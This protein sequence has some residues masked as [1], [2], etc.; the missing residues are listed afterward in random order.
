MPCKGSE[1]RILFPIAT[2]GNEAVS[3]P[4]YYSVLLRASCVSVNMA[5]AR[6]V[7]TC[8]VALR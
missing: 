2:L 1:W 3:T 6:L 7:W 4:L 5:S 8:V